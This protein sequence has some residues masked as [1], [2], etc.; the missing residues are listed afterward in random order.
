MALAVCHLMPDHWVHL[1]GST[2]RQ[3]LRDPPRVGTAVGDLSGP[4][5]RLA[6]VD[7]DPPS[8]QKVSIA[9]SQALAAQLAPDTT[10]TRCREQRR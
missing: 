7:T 4:A 3:E 10:R 6:Y 8:G 1:D 2:P 9:R 5:A